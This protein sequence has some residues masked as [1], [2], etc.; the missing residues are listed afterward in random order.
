[1]KFHEIF[2]FSVL[3]VLNRRG[4]WVEKVLNKTVFLGG[5]PSLRAFSSWTL[6]SPEVPIYETTC[7][8]AYLIF[9][10]DAI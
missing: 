5:G 8:C 7:L 3:G 6:E 10:L 4:G 1:M 2:D 9:I